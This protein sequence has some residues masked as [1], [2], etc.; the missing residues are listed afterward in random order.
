MRSILVPVDFT[1]HTANAAR[2]AADMAAAISADIQLIHVW[3]IPE[4]TADGPL[5]NDVL[6]E[7]R[8]SCLS[9]LDNLATELIQRTG[10]KVHVTTHFETG[11]M[12]TS[13]ETFCLWKNPFLIV[14][15]PLPM[16]LNRRLAFPVLVV[17]PRTVF[18]PIHRVV[19]ACDH[20]D[21]STGIPIPIDFFQRIR[22]LFGAR[23]ELVHVSI[24]EE[25]DK[26]KAIAAF[27]KWKDKLV[28]GF[29]EIHYTHAASVEEGISQYLYSHPADWLIVF[30]KKTGLFRFHK[31]L[32]TGIILH[33]PLPTLSV[34]S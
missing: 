26:K 21:I 10:C 13:I 22:D 7:I 15:S 30:P 24:R 19:L 20:E 2:Y 17:P 29:P 31:D 11:D 3:R 27:S 25:N 8:N 9:S 1:E 16:L 12:G 28:N 34:T 4:V 5:A 14:T 18:H 32:S 6:E 33:C 23:F